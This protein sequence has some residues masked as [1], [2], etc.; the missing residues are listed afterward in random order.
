MKKYRNYFG[1]I[2]L[3]ALECIVSG[4]VQFDNF[5]ITDKPYVEQTSVELYIGTGAGDY[6]RIQLVSNPKDK[7]YTWTS[8][9]P[10][11]A[12]VTQTGLVTAIKEGFAEITVASANDQTRINV[13]VRSWIPLE[14]FTLDKYQV[15]VKR[16]GRVQILLNPVPLNASKV[17]VQ[18]TSSNPEVASVFEN[19]W[20]VGNE[21]GSAIITASVGGFTQQVKVEVT[22]ELIKYP[23]AKWTIPGNNP[24]VTGGPKIGYSSQ[25]N[26]WL[27]N[28]FDGN[29]GT[30]WTSAY[31]S[32]GGFNS[33]YPHWFIVDMH[34]T[35]NIEQVMMQRRESLVTNG[36][37]EFYTC[38]DVEVNQDDPE[39]G[40][41]W[42]LQGKF[43]FADPNSTAEQRFVLKGSP[44]AR[45]L[46]VMIPK[47]CQANASRTFVDIAEFAIYGY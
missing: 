4:C 8:L 39:N 32:N 37:F 1:F 16:L 44:E 20:I 29:P 35:H 22:Q 34:R 47:D 24:Q 15:E 42:V 28:M 38:P 13:W 7:Q 9:D 21:V 19:G 23:R 25:S 31:A 41:P 30:F 11:I 45:Y 5:N 33:N 17:E 46:R 14:D 40:Y 12:T 43:I 18:W 36:G 2:F 10:S 26:Y 6:N 27:I 3:M